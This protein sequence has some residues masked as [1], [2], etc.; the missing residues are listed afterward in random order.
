LNA[1]KIIRDSS[2]QVKIISAVRAAGGEDKSNSVGSA[3]KGLQS[4]I[5]EV[6]KEVQASSIKNKFKATVQTTI[7][8]NKVINA[9]KK[10][11]GKK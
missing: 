11:S 6:I 4:N 5:Q 9:W 2:I 3:I 8:I 1:A 10:R 7:A